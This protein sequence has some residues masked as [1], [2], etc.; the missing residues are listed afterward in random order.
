LRRW[1]A[2]V[3]E[4]LYTLDLRKSA[5]PRGAH[6]DEYKPGM[7]RLLEDLASRSSRRRL[8]E[9]DYSEPAIEMVAEQFFGSVR[10]PTK[11]CFG[12]PFFAYFYGLATVET[13]YVLHL[14]CDVL[15][16][17]GSSMW[18]SEAIDLLTERPDVL[19]VS[20][21]AGPPTPTGRI[22]SHMW[23]A[24]RRTQAFGSEPVL[25][26]RQ[27]RTYRLRHVSSRVFF[28]DMDRLRGTT[29]L[30]VMDAPPWSFG[31]DLATT[32]YLP[33]ETVLSR[34]MHEGRWLRV[35]YLGKAPGMWFLH[36][37]QRGPGFSANLPNLVK[38]IE[39]DN[40][41]ERQ[42][43][44]FELRDDWLDAVGPARFV[45][46]REPVTARRVLGAAARVSGAGAVRKAIWRARWNR[47]HR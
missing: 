38:A 33:A 37:A 19:F 28:T 43:G 46:P 44:S 18:I 8:V 10:P 9:V 32:P 26:D 13:R 17:G 22:P 15:F 14:D 27:T 47:D 24:Q 2:Q 39:Q 40:V 45:P 36:P 23:R 3:D 42:R 35:D 1:S 11:D 31:T 21:L 6:F 30:P 7:L 29:P 41:P 12:A 16:G 20:P 34:T 5:G 4:V 25:E